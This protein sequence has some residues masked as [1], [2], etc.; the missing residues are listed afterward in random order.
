M[1][2]VGHVKK[3][4]MNNHIKDTITLLSNERYVHID[5][6]EAS[7][8]PSIGEFGDYTINLDDKIDNLESKIYIL[9]KDFHNELPLEFVLEELSKLGHSVSLIYDDCG[10]WSIAVDGFQNISAT[11]E[12]VDMQITHYIDKELWFSTIPEALSNYF[13]HD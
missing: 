13:K 3:Y 2:E 1:A 8:D 11:N 12:P 7:Y 9:L 4:I 6:Q 5:K 10:H